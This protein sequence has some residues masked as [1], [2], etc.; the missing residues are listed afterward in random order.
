MCLNSHPVRRRLWGA[1]KRLCVSTKCRFSYV[2]V[3]SQAA[4][5]FFSLFCFLTLRKWHRMLTH[6]PDCNLVS[7]DSIWFVWGVFFFLKWVS[8]QIMKNLAKVMCILF[9]EEK[10]KPCYKMNRLIDEPSVG[11]FYV[12]HVKCSHGGPQIGIHFYRLFY[13]FTLLTLPSYSQ[14]SDCIPSGPK[15]P[16]QTFPSYPVPSTQPRPHSGIHPSET[17]SANGQVGLSCVLSEFPTTSP[18]D[19]HW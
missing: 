15:A 3:Q 13:F 12:G 1:A 11:G 14:D 5:L 18:E 8:F 4:L 2:S 7:K 19:R 10:K 6:L 16:H 17:T 9:Q